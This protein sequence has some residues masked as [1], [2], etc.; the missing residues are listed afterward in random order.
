MATPNSR[1]G[2]APLAPAPPRDRDA[3][4]PNPVAYRFAQNLARSRKEL[5]CS[6]EELGYRASLHRTEISLLER[7]ARIPRIDTLIKLAQSLEL[8]PEVLLSGI[9][10]NAGLVTTG[11]FSVE[12][13]K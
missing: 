3:F 2:A 8:P 9:V 7:G 10:W 12:G 13:R 11:K 4:L 6:Q 5:D 1:D